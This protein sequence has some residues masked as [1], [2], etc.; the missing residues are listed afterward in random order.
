M[1]RQVMQDLDAVGILIIQVTDT[2]E[3]EGVATLKTAFEDL[4][5]TLDDKRRAL[6][7]EQWAF[8]G[9]CGCE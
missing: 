2:L 3:R 8:R 4:L 6:A 7:Q 1:A 9:R 5:H